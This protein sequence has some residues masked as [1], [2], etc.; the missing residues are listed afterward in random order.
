MILYVFNHYFPDS[1]GFGKRCFREIKALSEKEA[2]TVI[3]RKRIDEPAR[4]TLPFTAHPIVMLRY[5]ASSEIVHRPIGYKS[6]GLYEVRRILDIFFQCFFTLMKAVRSVPKTENVNIFVVSSPLTVPLI[7]WLVAKLTRA[8]T[9]LLSFHDLEPELAMHLKK[10]PYSHWIVKTEL[11]LEKIM[12]RSYEKTLVSTSSQAQRIATRTGVDISRFCVIVNSNVV[13]SDPQ[14]DSRKE[15]ALPTSF[16]SAN[17][18]TLCYLSTIS[19]DYTVEGLIDFLRQLKLE[20]AESNN[21]KMIIIGGGEGLEKIKSFIKGEDM[22]T[23]VYCSGFMKDT[24]SL[25][26]K[27]DAAVIPW[28]KDGMTET[29][30]PSKLFEYLSLGIPVIAPSF[31][32]FSKTLEDEKTALLYTEIPQ[33][34]TKVLHLQKNATVRQTLSRK[35]KELYMSQFHPDILK[36]KLLSFLYR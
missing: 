33:I 5:S 12:C 32:E 3:C 36:E 34:Y 4:E 27:A 22:S 6:N 18:F 23:Y 29:I 31:G 14:S 28:R 35:G 7:G 26:S 10:L 21:I 19:F 16:T 17:A 30:L 8:K 1:S 15:Y 13:P 9:K 11:F 20:N 25:L 24:A 2:V